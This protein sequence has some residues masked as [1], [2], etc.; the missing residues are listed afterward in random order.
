MKIGTKFTALTALLALLAA[1]A[2]SC[3]VPRQLLGAEEHACC[4]ET[5]DRCGSKKMASPKS[6]CETADES[7]QPYITAATNPQIIDAPAVLGVL[8]PTLNVNPAAQSISAVA[9]LAHSPPGSPPETVSIL[10]I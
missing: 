6:C 3:L 1:P 2:L 4:R 7:G 8:L 10:R 5:G 9:V